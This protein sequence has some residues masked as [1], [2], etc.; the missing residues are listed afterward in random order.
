MI[1]FLLFGT[2]WV[3]EALIFILT[4]SFLFFFGWIF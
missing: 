1:R 4:S 3:I 2:A